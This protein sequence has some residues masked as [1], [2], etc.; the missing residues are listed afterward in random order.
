ML[1]FLMKK[2]IYMP[3]RHRGCERGVLG[4]GVAPPLDAAERERGPAGTG[5]GAE[6]N[7]A[8]HPRPH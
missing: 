7:V 3:G 1:K 8:G 6:E 4:L 2:P 5:R